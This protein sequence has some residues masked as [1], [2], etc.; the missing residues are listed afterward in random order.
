MWYIYRCDTCIYITFYQTSPW[1]WLYMKKWKISGRPLKYHPHQAKQ[2]H[3]FHAHQIWVRQNRSLLS[4]RVRPLCTETL[5]FLISTKLEEA[6]IG[7]IHNCPKWPCHRSVNKG[8]SLFDLL[9]LQSWAQFLY[10]YYY[11]II[12]C[13]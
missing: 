13:I 11:Y 3:F 4:S 1:F 12:V 5:L 6:N 10:Y 8:P 9:F 7:M 2:K